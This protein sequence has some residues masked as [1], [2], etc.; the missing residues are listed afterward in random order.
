MLSPNPFD[1]TLCGEIPSAQNTI[2]TFMLCVGT[3]LSYLPQH[4]KIIRHRTSEGISPYF[5]LLGTTGAGSNITNMII[6][7]FIVM[8]CCTVQTWGVCV[9]SLL[10]IFQ[11]GIQSTMF[12]ITFVLF[13]TFFPEANKYE[14][15]PA[16]D[17]AVANSESSPLLPATAVADGAPKRLA[18]EWKAALWVAT[19]VA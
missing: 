10:G 11:V 12:Y 6:L 18:M 2:L 5:I 8:Q 1:P 17:E 9:A 4:I 7:Q 16:G 13:L 3:F 15:V 19:A 14:A